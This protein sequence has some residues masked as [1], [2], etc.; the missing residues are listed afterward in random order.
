MV[1]DSVQYFIKLGQYLRTEE[2]HIKSDLLAS[3]EIT[4]RSGN[5]RLAFWHDNE[6]CWA[7][8][9]W[10]DMVP[11]LALCRHMCLHLDCV[12]FDTSL[13]PDSEL[14]S[15]IIF[16]FKDNF[17]SSRHFCHLLL[18]IS[19][20]RHLFLSVSLAASNIHLFFSL[21]SGL[22]FNLLTISCHFS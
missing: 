16:F 12:S 13:A 11:L 22:Y 2:F 3:L 6:P 1:S 15:I 8:A 19:Y 21:L 18:T 20:Q 10:C 4:R 14:P 7:S 5:I 9:V 17:F